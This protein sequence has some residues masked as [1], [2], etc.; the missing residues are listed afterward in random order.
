MVIV[1]FCENLSG[2]TLPFAG[3]AGALFTFVTGLSYR[4]WLNREEARGTRDVEIS[5]VSVRRG[6]AILGIGFAFNVLV[7]LPEDTF[8]WDVLTFIGFAWVVLGVARKLPLSTLI[9][10]AVVS[11]VLSPGLREW[12]EYPAYWESG[13]FEYD[14]TMTDVLSGWLVTGYF[15]I[16]PWIAYPLTGFVTAS[17]LFAKPQESC[18]RAGR[19]GLIGAALVTTAAVAL[20]LRPLLPEGIGEHFL[21][22][23][24]MNPPTVT[25]VLGTVGVALL[26][27]G[28]LH[29]WVDCNPRLSKRSA[30]LDVAKTFS[31]YSLTIYILHHVV[32][33]WPLWIYGAVTQDEPTY[34]LEE[35]MPT[36]VAFLLA[37]LFM[38]CC[39]VVLRR[40]GPDRRLGVEAWVRWLC[41]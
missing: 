24:S 27:L 6:L 32:H 1:H 36:T 39:H 29:R 13:D 11:V 7:W 31:Q 17:L 15:P 21:G 2:Y 23:W 30:F 16:F 20:A 40:I 10:F 26:L 14:F 12:A 8:L 33:L 19:T 41:D 18:S 9:L 22:R 5:K 37:L 38:A 28:L 35:A 3:L 25:Y 34:Y 4:L